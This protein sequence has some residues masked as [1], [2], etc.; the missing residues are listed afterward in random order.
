MLTDLSLRHLPEEPQHENGALTLGQLVEQWTKGLVIF[1]VV[2]F[3]V[4]LADPL[5]QGDAAV[6]SD[7]IQRGGVIV[8]L[9]LERVD[10]L[11]PV[12]AEVL[13]EFT[14]SGGVAELLRQRFGGVLDRYAQIFEASRHPC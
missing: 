6:G 12:G 13:G 11:L 14:G 3:L 7:G 10:D 9:G 1:D 2:E 8:G 4:E 5:C